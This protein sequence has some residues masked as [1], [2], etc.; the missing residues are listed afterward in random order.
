[1][2]INKEGVCMINKINNKGFT[3]A[4]A[5]VAML[6]VAIMAAG[7]IVALMSTK[8]AIIAPTNREE[9]LLAIEEVSSILQ[10]AT[11][12]TPALCGQ[13]GYA[14]D[15]TTGCA[16]NDA[17]ARANCHNIAC[18]RP[19]SCRGND[20][21]FIYSVGVDNT[22]NQNQKYINFMISCEGQTI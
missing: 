18:K 11:E 2:T 17:S 4:E 16:Q 12:T 5:L 14:L 8:R 7:I 10:G 19:S 6:L 20:D 1:M 9:M 15:V 13:T 21:Y 3:L 22:N